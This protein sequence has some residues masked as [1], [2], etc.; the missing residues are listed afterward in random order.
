MTLEKKTA[1]PEALVAASAG[2]PSVPENNTSIAGSASESNAR[3]EEME[4]LF[5]RLK[6][7]ND[8]NRL[9]SITINELFNE[10]YRGKPPVIEGILYTGIYLFAGAP[11]VG[12]SFLMAQLAYHVS[13]GTPLWGYPVQ[14]GT[15]LY[16]ALEDDFARLQRRFYRMFGIVSAEQLH[17]A[18]Q[19]GH[20]DGGLEAQLDGFLYD[21]PDTKLIIIDTLQK[22]R[23]LA[24]AQ[25]SYANDYEIMCRL[26]TFA[27]Q[28]RICLLL[29]H[30]TRKQQAED[31]FDMISG[32]NGLMGAADGAFLFHKEK[33]TSNRA[34]LDISGRDQQDQRLYLV[35]DEQKLCWN[36]ERSENE[37]WKEPPDPIL[38]AVARLL[39][40][41]CPLWEG[42]PTELVKALELNLKPQVLTMRLNVNAER[43]LEEHR[44][45]YSNTRNHAGRRIQLRLIPDPL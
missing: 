45:H 30:H 41:V 7:M 32:T 37:L 35:R 4:L 22:V 12:K 3:D 28:H 23:E 21:Y 18:I 11:K 34:V 16:L 9:Y 15:V 19:A 40:P 26:K 1:P 2:Q 24:P 14:Q 31:T 5:R 39:Y 25:Y 33:R 13:T 36:L 8:P 43:L 6:Q 17:V 20:L 44:I 27:D 29:V 10:M 42:A 38:E